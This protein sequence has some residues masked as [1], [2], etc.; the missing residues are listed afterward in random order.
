MN[1]ISETIG[2]LHLKFTSRFANYYCLVGHVG[3]PKITH[4]HCLGQDHAEAL[5]AYDRIRG[6]MEKLALALEG[7]IC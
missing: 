6:R 2:P 1:L 7:K 5:E 3:I 4:Q